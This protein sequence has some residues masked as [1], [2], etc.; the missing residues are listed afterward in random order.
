[1]MTAKYALFWSKI[2]ERKKERALKRRIRTKFKNKIKEYIKYDGSTKMTV[3]IQKGDRFWP[4]ISYA[5]EWLEKKGYKCS[6]EIL[7]DEYSD[8]CYRIIVSWGEEKEE[9]HPF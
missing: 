4:L 9:E 5:A 6:Y 1:M 7:K 8:E 2:Y 3:Y